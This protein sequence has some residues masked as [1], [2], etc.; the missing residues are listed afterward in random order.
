MNNES[1]IESFIKLFNEDTQS[2]T[3]IKSG[4]EIKF[5]LNTTDV[6][7][8]S[9]LIKEL[10]SDVDIITN[11][12]TINL[13][14]CKISNCYF[15]FDI[16]DYLISFDRYKNDYLESNIIVLKYFKNS[17]W[18][19]SGEEFSQEKA[20][21]FNFPIYKEAYE[22]LKNNPLFT[23]LYG[24]IKNELIIVNKG[25]GA[26]HIGY[27]D[28]EENVCLLENLRPLIELLKVNFEKKE[29]IQFFKENI[30]V[31]GIGNTDPQERFFEII[32]NLKPIL[33]ITERDY[34]NY[35]RDFN[36]ENIKTQ[37]K[38]ERN[39][40]FEG[41]EK[42]IELVN[43]QVLSIPLT[44]A[45]TAFASYQVKDKPIIVVLILFA[46][47]LYSIIAFK[48]LG[49]SNFNIKCIEEDVIK[50]EEE[51]KNNYSK[52]YNHFKVDFEKIHSK[53]IK[54]NSLISCIKF[55]LV[56]MLLLFTVFS[57]IQFF[58]NKELKKE[59]ISIPIDKIKYIP[60]DTL[61]IRK[62]IQSP[63]RLKRIK[64]KVVNR[65][66]KSN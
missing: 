50:E 42:N 5:S 37:F 21:F 49:I 17:L 38:E 61:V 43:K 20:L 12:V 27:K 13:N 54:I 30:I 24:G 8:Q 18:K 40:Y 53:I 58:N 48:M 39:K 55:I 28:L 31:F 14:K 44:F 22:F 1:L 33:L 65:I 6:Q 64:D 41:L 66:D 62:D 34:E 26:F 19:L 36:F 63:K 46:F 16:K 52:N 29:F 10:F 47:I 2:D 23:T 9:Q 4:V 57:T 60:I 56:V 35:V 32:K 3:I 59:M 15:F 7:S 45:A 11:K 25:N 51:I